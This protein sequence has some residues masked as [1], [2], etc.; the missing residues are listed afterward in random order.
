MIDLQSLVWL[1]FSV[2]V[3]GGIAAVLLLAMREAWD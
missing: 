1:G 3:G 2:W